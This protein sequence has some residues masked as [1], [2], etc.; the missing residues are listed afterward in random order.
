MAE[1]VRRH[2]QLEAL[3]AEQQRAAHQAG[4]ADQAGDAVVTGQQ[5]GR[6]VR[7][8]VEIGEVEFD[9]AGRAG[10]CQLC[11]GLLAATHVAGRKHDVR[12][13]SNEVAGG[14]ETDA[15]VGA[16][17]DVRAASES[18]GR[19]GHTVIAILPRTC[20]ASRRRIA[21]GASARG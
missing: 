1:V 9:D 17:H 18:C 10:T 11:G 5:D 19:R 3:S 7:R 2:L 13:A 8:L 14:L 6:R 4:V 15:A 20:P 21:A 16:R 12:A